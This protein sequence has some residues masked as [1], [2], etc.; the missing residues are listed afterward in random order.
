MLYQDALAEN[1]ILKDV[2]ECILD[3][4]KSQDKPHLERCGK[5]KGTL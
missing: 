4:P 1:H 5:K 3:I 2:D